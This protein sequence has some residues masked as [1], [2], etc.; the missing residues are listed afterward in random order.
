MPHRWAAQHPGAERRFDRDTLPYQRVRVP[1]QDNHCDCG[2]FVLAHIEFFLWGALGLLAAL[3]RPQQ[4]LAQLLQQGQPAGAQQDPE[5]VLAA[6]EA[7][8]QLARQAEQGPPPGHGPQE[9]HSSRGSHPML[10]INCKGVSAPRP[11]PPRGPP[12]PSALPRALYTARASP[13]PGPSPRPAR[14]PARPPRPAPPRRWRA[15]PPAARRSAASPT[16]CAPAGSACATRA[17]CG[18][19]SSTWRSRWAGGGGAAVGVWR[20]VCA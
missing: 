7:Q 14:Q 5:Q 6:A 3:A 9:G 12:E 20:G 15:A 19:T 8:A 18:S 11:G 1:Q 2:L 13:Q 10:L 16:S 17:R 4:A